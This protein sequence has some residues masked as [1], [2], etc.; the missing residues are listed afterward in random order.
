M[1]W[2]GTAVTV[3]QFDD[4]DLL[5]FRVTSVRRLAD[6]IVPVLG[7][8]GLWF[9]WHIDLSW[10]VLAGFLALIGFPAWRWVQVR[11]AELR[12]TEHD[13]VAEGDIESE[14]STIWLLWS[15]VSSL[16][17]RQG[18]RRGMEGAFEAKGLYALLGMEDCVC[19]LPNVS[20]AQADAIVDA[21]YSRFPFIARVEV[22]ETP[23]F[24]GKRNEPMTLGSTGD[25]DV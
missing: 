16:Q 7:G 11:V 22:A 19:L 8:L 1:R 15:E 24:S 3:E 2:F 9:A 18:R 5:R 21:I 23:S 13:L 6:L 12:V 4:G 20:D 14:T 25:E 10:L 17:F